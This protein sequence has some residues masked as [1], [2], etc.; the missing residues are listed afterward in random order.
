MNRAVISDTSCLIAL[1]RIQRLEI[2]KDVF[3]EIITTKEVKREFGKP[4]PKWIVIKNAKDSRK[5]MELTNLLD[6]GEA[7][8]IALVLETKNT[9]LIIDEKKG[10]RI[11]RELKIAVI[12]TLRVLLF[13]K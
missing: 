12:G 13:A 11:A 2:L 5:K 3:S 1:E 6:A 4:L 7:S 8:A 10:R 9:L